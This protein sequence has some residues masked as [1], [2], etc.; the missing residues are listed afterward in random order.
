[1]MNVA[2]RN[3]VMPYCTSTGT[4][5]GMTTPRDPS[6]SEPVDR[7][8]FITRAPGMPLFGGGTTDSVLVQPKPSLI[9]NT[10]AAWQASAEQKAM[11]LYRFLRVFV[12]AVA[13]QVITQIVARGGVSDLTRQAVIALI[14]AAAETVWRQMRPALTAAAV[15]SAPGA[16]LVPPRPPQV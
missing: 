7:P 8:E 1:M 12:L 6:G 13:T 10:R 14:V 15:D 2:E 16:T 3:A 9:P 4:L 5:A 11:Q